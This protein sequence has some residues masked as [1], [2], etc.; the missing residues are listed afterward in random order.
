MK[1]LDKDSLKMI[2]ILAGENGTFAVQLGLQ[3]LVLVGELPVRQQK[4]MVQPSPVGRA[5]LERG[6]VS[7]ICEDSR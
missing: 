1:K 4:F 2:V 6:N 3:Q 5:R 7:I